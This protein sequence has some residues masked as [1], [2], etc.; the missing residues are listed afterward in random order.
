MDDQLGLFLAGQAAFSVRV[1]DVGS[2]QWD[3][4]TPDRDWTVADLVDHL[5]D[6]QRWV[7]PLMSGASVEEAQKTVEAL[8]NSAAAGDRDAAWQEAASLAAAAFAA[9]GALERSVALS[10]GPTPAREYLNEMIFDLCVHSW[11]LG[12]A[13]ESPHRLPE[14]LVAVTYEAVQSFGDLS[15]TGLFDSAVEVPADAPLVDRL[16]AFTGRDPRW[17]PAR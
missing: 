14:D 6:E 2:G 8:A 3:D 11:D 4:P 17:T 12:A 15:S 5:I 9:E 7:A 16:V 13:I 1:A 10:R